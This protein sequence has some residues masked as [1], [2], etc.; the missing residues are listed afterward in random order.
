MLKD[1]FSTF[2]M[3][4]DE[5]IP[6]MFYRL[7]VIVNDLKGLREK[8]EDKDFSHKFL[9]Y[10]PKK[11]TTLR[12]MIFREELDKVKPTD[13]LEDIMTDAQYNDDEDKEEEKKET[14]VKQE[15]PIAFK[16]SSSKGKSKVESDDDDPFDD[17]T[18][19]LLVHKMGRFMKKKG[20]GERKRRDTMKAKTLCY[21]YNSPD[22]I[23]TDCPYEDKRF[24]NGDLKLKKN[25]KDKKEKEKKAKKSFTFNK[26]KKGGGYV[27]TWDSNNLDSVD[28]ASSSDDERTTRRAIASIAL[29]NKPSIF[30]TTSTCLMAKPTK[31][32]YDDSDDDSCA[33]DGY[34]SDE[35]EDEDYSKDNL[36]GIIDQMSKGYKRTTKKYKILE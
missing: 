13:V 20:Y 23:V 31:V 32:K 14:E 5:S 17:E 18:M 30:D 4:D 28:D 10:L 36:L 9:M 34:R 2:K 11:F 16:A 33:S 22:H 7:Q 25:K 29:S 19:A 27:V 1:K 15:K 26:K 6:E 35:E 24:H 8:V 21:N 3:K 12:R